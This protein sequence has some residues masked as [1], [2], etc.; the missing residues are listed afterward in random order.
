MHIHT[1]DQ[2]QHTHHFTPD[3]RQSERRTHIV[4]GLTLTMMVLE[5]AGGMVFGSMA[6]LADGWH[7]ATHVAALSITAIAYWYAR[8]HRDNPRYSFGTG[9]VGVL[10]GFASAVALAVVAL[11]M[12]L[13]SMQR[14]FMDVTIHF[15]EA[16]AVATVGLVVNLVSALLLRDHHDHHHH[17]HDDHTHPH[18]HNLRAAYLHV[19][20]DALTSLLAIIALVAGMFLGWIWL[21]AV[22]GIV[23]ALVITRWSWGLLRDTSVILLD[24]DV[25]PSTVQ[26][27]RAVVEAEA[28]NRIADLHIWRVGPH[29]LAVIISVVT[30]YPQPPEH[31]K[32]LL[33]DIPDLAHISVEVQ[34]CMSEPCLPHTA[35]T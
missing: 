24:S 3:D 28:D 21:D 11:V 34:P 1:L 10:G 16:I 25:D 18:D 17:N 8:H 14:F 22:M 27:V 31:Y 33:R 13:E 15:P 20:A 35:A 32:A 12:A 30:H 9:K 23:G 6:L 4:I 19:L 2:W 29:H 26:A 5:I 7:M